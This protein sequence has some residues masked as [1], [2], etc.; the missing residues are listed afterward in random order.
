MVEINGSSVFAAFGMC[1]RARSRSHR[2]GRDIGSSQNC[3]EAFDAFVDVVFDVLPGNAGFV[4]YLR[5]VLFG[6]VE[7]KI[8]LN[9]VPVLDGYLFER[10]V[11]VQF[12]T[13]ILG[14]GSPV[15]YGLVAEIKIGR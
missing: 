1:W 7:S 10:F 15:A 5:H 6:A 3:S 13:Y 14:E 4:G 8:A 2:S 11:E 12:E 9:G